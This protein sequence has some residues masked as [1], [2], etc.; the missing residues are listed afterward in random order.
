ML[1]AKK[2]KKES[3]LNRGFGL[4]ILEKVGVGDLIMEYAGEAIDSTTKKIRT[5]EP[6][7]DYYIM[8]LTQGWFI[9]ARMVG[10]LSRFINHSC[11]PNCISKQIVVKGQHR[12][13]I[14][15]KRNIGANEF[16][17]IDYKYQFTC[18]CGSKNCR[19]TGQSGGS[20]KQKQG[21]VIDS[22][23]RKRGG[24]RI[25]YPPNFNDMN[26]DEFKAWDKEAI[27][28]RK[29]A[30]GAKS[31]AKKKL[32]Q[33]D[34]KKAAGVSLMDSLFVTPYISLDIVT[35]HA[36]LPFTAITCH[37]PSISTDT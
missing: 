2:C 24:Q 30:S 34:R 5:N 25:Y 37:I 27:R 9:D 18:F 32:E 26:P 36:K 7:D 4:K 16:L 20:T 17:S 29:R 13:G 19:G 11:D 10:N 28:E 8:S 31:Y 35:P 1:Q 21:A 12:C 3:E 6:H 14:Y 15:A 33:H 23:K 22:V